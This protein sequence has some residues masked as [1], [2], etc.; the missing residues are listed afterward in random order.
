NANYTNYT[1]VV[2]TNGTCEQAAEPEGQTPL[3]FDKRDLPKIIGG[4]DGNG[5]RSSNDTTTS[6]SST[7][8]NGRHKKTSTKRTIF[9]PKAEQ[10]DG[11]DLERIGGKS[12]AIELAGKGYF[13]GL[14]NAS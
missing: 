13:S 14:K 6:S 12:L 2:E 11:S 7:L 3:P 8:V 9:I 4:G 10:P 1:I 5:Y